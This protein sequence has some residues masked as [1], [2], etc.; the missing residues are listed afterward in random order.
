MYDTFI[1]CIQSILA[2][3][4]LPVSGRHLFQGR[5]VIYDNYYAPKQSN[6]LTPTASDYPLIKG[7]A[8][9]G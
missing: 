1:L 4:A 5:D 9:S 3:G 2:S 7:P 6:S 8:D